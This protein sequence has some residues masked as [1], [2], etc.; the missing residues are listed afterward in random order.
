[1]HF[2]SSFLLVRGGWEGQQKGFAPLVFRL[3]RIPISKV[4]LHRRLPFNKFEVHAIANIVVRIVAVDLLFDKVE[5]A[6]DDFWRHQ[7]ALH[8]VLQDVFLWESML[9]R[10]LDQ[11]W[12]HSLSFFMKVVSIIYLCP[13]QR[14]KSV[15][16]E[17]R[18]V[19][20]VDR[21]GWSS[22]PSLLSDLPNHTPQSAVR[23][24]QR[25]VKRIITFLRVGLG[26][27]DE[28]VAKNGGGPFAHYVVFEK[29]ELFEEHIPSSRQRRGEK[30]TRTQFLRRSL[31]SMKASEHWVVQQWV[32]VPAKK[33]KR[34]MRKKSRSGVRDVPETWE[35]CLSSCRWVESWSSDERDETGREE[36]SKSTKKKKVLHSSEIPVFNTRVTS[37]T[38]RNESEVTL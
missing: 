27:V 16:E 37:K 2:R 3:P 29:S 1:M 20:I 31:A 8:F 34:A 35:C 13:A 21:G 25:R 32:R 4:F 10:K 33:K 36:M 7:I 9:F 6:S 24:C 18:E 38:E 30:N 26:K 19:I 5:L 11:R 17:E 22:S 14:Q 12:V 23:F 28:G 15:K